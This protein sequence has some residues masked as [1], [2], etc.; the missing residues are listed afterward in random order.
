VLWRRRPGRPSPNEL[1]VLFE[2]AALAGLALVA[3]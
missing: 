2:A 1:A 3:E